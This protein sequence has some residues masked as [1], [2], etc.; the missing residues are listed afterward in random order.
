MEN[1][2]E[3][4]KPARNWTFTMCIVGTIAAFASMTAAEG[5]GWSPL[6]FLLI[7]LV[8]T[9][10][11]AKLLRRR[12]RP[13]TA[14]GLAIVL[15]GITCFG[16]A[17]FST[18]IDPQVAFAR[19]FAVPVP[20][21]MTLL[22]SRKQ[23]YD[24]VDYVITFQSDRAAIDSLLSLRKYEDGSDGTAEFQRMQLVPPF[25]DVSQLVP[26]SYGGTR[27]WTY[28]KELSEIQWFHVV[29]SWDEKSGR[30]VIRTSWS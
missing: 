13:W 24:G 12:V 9:P 27:L 1:E 16:L 2:A 14:P 23:W 4:A 22:D 10:L 3:T 15:V 17:K 25:M 18:R 28:H 6:A 26:A 7:G 19:A 29:I 5:Y 20:P 11:L 8:G 30:G 21:G